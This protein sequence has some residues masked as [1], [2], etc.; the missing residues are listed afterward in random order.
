V[1]SRSTGRY[2]VTDKLAE[3]QRRG[4][5]EIWLIHPCERTLTAWRRRHD[6]GY[7]QMVITEGIVRP[8]ALPGV[9]IDLATLFE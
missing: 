4:D 5:V 8:T 3:Y 6:G 7:D 9:A 2:D 1:W